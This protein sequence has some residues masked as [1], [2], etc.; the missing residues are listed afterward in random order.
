MNEFTA[1]LAAFR[2]GRRELAG[3]EAAARTARTDPAVSAQ[4][5]DE[6]GRLY[7]TGR[8]PPQVSAALKRAFAGDGVEDRG[9]AA[10]APDDDRTRLH[11]RRRSAA[12]PPSSLHAGDPTPTNASIAEPSTSD[13]STGDSSTGDPSSGDSSTGEPST[14][15]GGSWSDPSSWGATPAGDIGPGSVLKG[16]FVLEQV[17][18]RG[19]MGVVYRARDL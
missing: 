1:T 8:L 6:S 11:P 12:V 10:P 13:S 18:G 15:G 17:V 5:L 9:T 16:R 14:G 4:A 7:R 2:A 19:G 3:V